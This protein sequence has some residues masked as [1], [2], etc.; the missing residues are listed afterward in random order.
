MAKKGLE[1]LMEK[2][3]GES[4]ISIASPES[5]RRMSADEL[6]RVN[7]QMEAE[8]RGQPEPAEETV[9]PAMSGAP[10]PEKKRMGRPAKDPAVK[11]KEVPLN[12]MVDAELKYRLEELRLKLYRSSRKD[13]VVEAL[14]DLFRK[15]DFE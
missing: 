3:F 14:H 5:T 12:T 9:A 6:K 4:S 10:V 13:L 15:Y 11:A 1:K 2:Q 7:E 8:R